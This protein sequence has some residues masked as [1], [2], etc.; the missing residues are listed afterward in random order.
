MEIEGKYD[1]NDQ[2]EKNPKNPNS[3][4]QTLAGMAGDA[5]NIGEVVAKNGLTLAESIMLN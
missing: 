1:K 2:E 5:K 4:L 3:C